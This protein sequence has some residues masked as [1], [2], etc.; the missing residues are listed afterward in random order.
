MAR[1]VPPSVPSHAS[2]AIQCSSKNDRGSR[3]FSPRRLPPL[4]AVASLA[5][6]QV[7]DETTALVRASLGAFCFETRMAGEPVSAYA[8]S[9]MLEEFLPT[10]LPRVSTV[11]SVSSRRTA[12]LR[13]DI[14]TAPQ[15]PPTPTGR[16]I[17]AYLAVPIVTPS[18]RSAPASSS[19]TGGRPF[20]TRARAPRRQHRG[21]IRDRP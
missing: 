15:F 9:G 20:H 1:R 3:L 13:R 5:D 11:R 10:T 14:R 17:V 12:S 8:T 21:T 16:P 4:S 2:L 18:G 6:Q 19:L 7:L